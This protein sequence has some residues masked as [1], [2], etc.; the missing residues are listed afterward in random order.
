MR[1]WLGALHSQRGPAFSGQLTSLLFISCYFLSKM[2]TLCRRTT[3]SVHVLA[4]CLIVGDA[5][6]GSEDNAVVS[7]VVVVVT[8]IMTAQ[9][10][11]VGTMWWWWHSFWSLFPRNTRAEEHILFTLIPS[12]S[13]SPRPPLA[14]LLADRRN[15]SPSHSLIL[16]LSSPGTSCL[17]LHLSL[18]TSLAHIILAITLC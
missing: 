6:G 11:V 15:K 2:L 8:V 1:K 12:S 14:H 10:V 16:S 18:G 5:G 4:V 3:A 7:T 9:V 13:V 17:F